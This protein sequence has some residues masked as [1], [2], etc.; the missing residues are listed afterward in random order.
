VQRTGEVLK[1][2]DELAGTVTKAQVAVIFDWENMWAL[3]DCQGYANAGKKYM[4][5]CYAYHR[6]F[7]EKGIDCDVVSPKADLSGYEIVVAP[8]LYLTDGQTIE[9]LKSYVLRGGNLYG[10]YMLGT[11]N[12]TDLCWL[13]GIPGGELKNVFGIV[14]EEIDTLYP[15]ERQH[16]TMDG[17]KH[18]LVDYCEVLQL[19]GAHPVATYADG[20]YEGMPAVTAHRY[21][22]GLAVY[23]ACRDTGSLKTQV[24]EALLKQQKV[25]VNVEG[26]LSYGVTAHSRT[27]GETTYVFVEN[28]SATE[29]ASVSLREKMVDL[30]TGEETDTVTLK[31]YGFG[32]FKTK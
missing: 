30:L 2:I 10:T 23:Q 16:A 8:M 11:V 18:E 31:P 20:Y 4:E 7:W 1:A 15:A 28:Y 24:L 17:A 14:A 21:G 12:E 6:V 32:L 3:D 5:T 22:H 29:T 26:M 19:H 13:G 9:N 27:D 25:K